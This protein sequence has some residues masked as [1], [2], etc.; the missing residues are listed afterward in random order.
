MTGPAIPPPRRWFAPGR[1]TPDIVGARVWRARMAALLMTAALLAGLGLQLQATHDTAIDS[2]ETL[3]TGLAKAI[4]EKLGGS[5]RAVDSLLDEA[6]GALEAER[7][8]D[9][10]VTQ[11]ILN[12]LELFPEVHFLGVFGADGRMRPPTWPKIDLPEN[13]L[14]ISGRAYFKRLIAPGPVPRLVV[15]YPV[16]GQ[17]TNRRSLHLVRP[18]VNGEGKLTGGVAAA[19]NPDVFA[20]FLETVMVDPDGAAAMIHIDGPMIAR[21]PDH[22]GKFAMNIAN[23]DLFKI[24]IPRARQ[25]TA[26]LISKAD[27][28]DKIIAYRVLDDYPLVVTC[29]IS[30]KVALADWRR[31]ALI[32]TILA[33]ALIAVI[34]YWAWRSDLSSGQMLAYGRQLEQAVEARTH[35]LAAARDDA[36][37]HARRLEKVNTELHRMAMVTAHHLQ[38]PLRPMVSYS[39]LL[40]QRL[41]SQD[42]ETLDMLTFIRQ[43]AV[44]LKALLRDFQRYVS[45]LTDRPHVARVD[46]ADVVRA[47]AQDVARHLGVA[48]LT[49]E[50]GDLPA[51]DADPALLRE[52]FRELLGNAAIHRG[53]AAA[54]H[55]AVACLRE[56][57][58]WVF[59]VVD[60]GPGI[61]P[62]LRERV[63]QVFENAARRDADATGLGLPLCRLIVEAHGG[64]LLIDANP[65]GRGTAIR[66]RLP[67]ADSARE[68]ASENPQGVAS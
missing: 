68:K 37:R 58:G 39:Q 16:T 60:D 61:P 56:P 5:I 48:A 40:E 24:W 43:A 42:H 10:V 15:G 63:M 46:S 67:V 65:Q 21:A 20:R 66:F 59:H 50:F 62:D 57:Q 26:Q 19:I 6:V 4:A 34:L 1:S 49:V 54:A 41:R 32:E 52:V 55:V 22:Q 53:R 28:N 11:R 33:A 2:A 23:S 7:R 8:D 9:P 64:E 14:D 45:A 51:V 29:G 27:G 36:A 35:E 47:A 3:V 13:G 25:G 30:R 18:L 12:R 31:L 38:E 44:R 17:A